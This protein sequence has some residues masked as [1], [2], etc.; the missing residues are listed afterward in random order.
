M[1]SE[2]IFTNKKIQLLGIVLLLQFVVSNSDNHE[3]IEQ[4]IRI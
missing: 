4:N 3:T 1:I 2:N